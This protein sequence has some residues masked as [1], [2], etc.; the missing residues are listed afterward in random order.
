MEM[1]AETEPE[2]NV[3]GTVVVTMTVDS[4]ATVLSLDENG[5]DDDFAVLLLLLLLLSGLLQPE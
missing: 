1:E 3:S 5:A 2:L 4:N